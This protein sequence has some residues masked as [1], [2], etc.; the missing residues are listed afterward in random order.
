MQVNPSILESARRVVQENSP[1][2]EPLEIPSYPGMVVGP[3]DSKGI[4]AISF[5]S[6]NNQR[7][8]VGSRRTG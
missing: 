4:S 2:Q 8:G 5:F 6:E 7:Y 1:L 3:S